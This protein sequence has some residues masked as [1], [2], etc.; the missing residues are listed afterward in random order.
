LQLNL[1]RILIALTIAGAL[2]LA[3]N[4]SASEDSRLTLTV[5][6]VIVGT[7][8]FSESTFH[9]TPD[10]AHA[11]DGEQTPAIHIDAAG[12]ISGAGF[13]ITIGGITYTDIEGHRAGKGW[14][15]TLTRSELEVNVI[16]SPY[17]DDVWAASANP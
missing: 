17:D 12:N 13:S 7:V 6:G 16:G 14:A 9:Y 2:P 3:G 5:G 4:Y 1:R 11:Q 8:D 15:G 10:G